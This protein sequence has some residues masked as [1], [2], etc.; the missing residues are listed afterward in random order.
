LE[1][2]YDILVH[3]NN[4]RLKDD[5]L[6]I[7]N[8]T[9]V[10]TAE[11]LLVFDTGGYVSRNGLIKALKGHGLEPDD[12]RLVFLS[13]LH[14]DHSHNIDLF[15]R[16]KVL[17]S[18]EECESAKAPHE[19]DLFMPWGIHEQLENH[20]PE[21]IQ[22]EGA[23]SNRISYFPATGHTPGCYCLQLDTDR[24]RVVIADDAI[25]YAKEV[26]TRRCDMAF[27]TIETGTESIRRTLEVA[28]PIIPGRF[29]ELIRHPDGAFSWDDCAPF[30]LL[31]R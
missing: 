7:A 30:E 25:K 13:H 23:L 4:L 21:L 24:G 29:P 1:P 28:D 22:G 9:L 5:Y 20:D 18:K 16:A 3:G 17:V 27:D 14:F 10:S 6:G 19:K 2:R 12:V 31:I 15:R 11:G 8:V 26:I